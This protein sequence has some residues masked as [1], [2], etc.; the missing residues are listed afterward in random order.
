[1]LK[2]LVQDEALLIQVLREIPD[3]ALIK[4]AAGAPVMVEFFADLQSPVSRPA[5]KVLDELLRRYPSTIRLQF[6]NFPLAF[7]P[8]AALA[9][10]AA[11][12]AAREGHFWEFA[13][14]ILGHQ[15]SLREQDLIGYAG[16]L[17]LNEAQFAQ[18]L[19]EH[20]YKSRVEA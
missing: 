14:F 3:S 1:Q 4:G 5:M 9:H 12:T 15:N 6:R 13:S 19:Q 17:G 20:R 18:T 11:M 7:H 16:R 8:Q 10:E 2:K